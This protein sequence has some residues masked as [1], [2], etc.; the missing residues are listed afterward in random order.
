[1]LL[2]L[3]TSTLT[4]SLALVSPAGALVAQHREGPP[5][6]Q[7]ELLPEAIATLLSKAGHTLAEVTH[8]VS[9]LGPGSFTGLR[10]G[11]AT[12]KGLAFAQRLPLVGVSS[13]E[14]L[15]AEGPEGVALFCAAVVKRGE[16]Y[17]GRYL[18]R[19][20]ALTLEGEEG[21]LTVPA[22]AQALRAAPAARMLGPALVDYRAELLALQVPAAQLLEGPLVPDAVALARRAIARGLPRAYDAAAVF[23]LEPRYLK[24][25]GAEDNPLFPPLPGPAPGARRA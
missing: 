10:I 22:F 13:L 4:M 8:L 24:G 12:L 15:A 14:A 5:R 18:R 6:K 11:L 19:G 1:V 17:L 25:S 21:V 3:D 7:S 16:L 2:A 23:A 9:G 20:D